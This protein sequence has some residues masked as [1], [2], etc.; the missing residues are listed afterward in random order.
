MRNAVQRIVTLAPHLAELVYAAGAGDRLVGVSAYSDYP[1]PVRELPLVGD[2]FMVD[3]EQLGLLRPDVVLA[4]Q[5]GT[6]AH[7]V[8]ELRQL[9]YRVEVIRTR[10]LDDIPA[11]LRQIGALAGTGQIAATAASRFADGVDALAESWSG[12]LPI[13]VFYQV[14]GRPLYTVNGDH[15]VSELITLCGGEN[16]FGDLRSL[17][18]TVT[19]EAVLALDPEVLLAAGV[20]GEDPFAHWARWPTLAAI[21]YGN[22]FL[23]PADEIGRATPRLLAAGRTICEFLDSGR[24]RRAVLLD[25]ASSVSRNRR[26]GCDSR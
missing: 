17:A 3:Q 24:Q 8:D 9:G 21:R 23:V 22:R 11:A 25:A 18:P 4:W 20:E 14:S 2:S 16:V 19:E 10:G 15:Y 12:A 13:R 7:V 5:S 26:P 6:P 1:R